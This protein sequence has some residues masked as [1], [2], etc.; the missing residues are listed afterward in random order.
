M[1][2]YYLKTPVISPDVL[3]FIPSVKRGVSVKHL[4]RFYQCLTRPV[5]YRQQGS[6][7]PR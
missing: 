6:P 4:A 2:K 7:R 3:T 1:G 5:I